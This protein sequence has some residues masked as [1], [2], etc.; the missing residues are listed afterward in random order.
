MKH[1][2]LFLSLILCCGLTAAFS[3]VGCG[4][5]EGDD[6]GGDR[7]SALCDK[8]AACGGHPPSSCARDCREDSSQETACILA[9]DTRVNCVNFE[10]CV[11]ACSAYY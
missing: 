1:C 7:C 9:C 11:E 5:D 3:M 2:K 4:D 8:V 6:N 10:I